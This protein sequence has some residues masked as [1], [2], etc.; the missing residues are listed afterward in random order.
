MLVL[1]TNATN[2]EGTDATLTQI[3]AHASNVR[4]AIVLS[5]ISSFCALVLAVTLYGITRDEDPDIAMIGMMC[6]VGEG[7]VGAIA[8][9]PILGLLWLATGNGQTTTDSGAKPLAAL[10]LQVSDWSTPIA[11][12]FFAV[13]STLFAYLFLRGRIVPVALAWLGLLG[14]VLIVITLPLQLVGLMSPRLATMM[15]Y[16]LLPYEVILALWLIFKGAAI[17]AHSSAPPAPVPSSA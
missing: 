10:L 3:A 1:L 13:G 4:I 9:L 11:A 17:P 7:F 2:A 15:W 14:S 5:L 12:L 8:I 6:R 16:P